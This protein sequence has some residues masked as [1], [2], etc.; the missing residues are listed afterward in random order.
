MERITALKSL[1]NRK[2]ERILFFLI[3]MNIASHGNCSNQEVSV[4]NYKDGHK[5]SSDLVGVPIKS[6][7]SHID[8][9]TFC[10][11][12]YFRF[13]R[14]SFL[15]SVEPDLILSIFDFENKK[16]EVIYQ[17]AFYPFSFHN[18]TILPES[19]QYVCLVVTSIQIKVVWNG[20]L[21]YKQH[22]K[23]ELPKEV[24]KNTKLWLGGALF[25]DVNRRLEGMIANAKFWNNALQDDDLIS[26]TTNNK[27]VISSA[28]YDLLSSTIP[29]NSSC[30]DYLILDENDYLFQDHNKHVHNIL[31]EYK[32]DFDSSNFICQGYGGNLTLPKNEEDLK[33]LGNLIKQSTLQKKEV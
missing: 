13:L 9:F 1:M 25:H 4:L 29:K 8:E 24:I 6:T 10:G 16:G 30:I 21:L 17:G 14:R 27:R 28:K 11:K 32:T 12:Y 2:M 15:M 31:I 7:S 19:W 23:F 3:L 22:Y 18:Q 26:I 5:C 33:T 20:E